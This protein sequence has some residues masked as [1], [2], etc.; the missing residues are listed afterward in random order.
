[1]MMMIYLGYM[2]DPAPPSQSVCSVHFTC[3]TYC[4]EQVHFTEL[5]FVG[6]VIWYVLHPWSSGRACVIFCVTA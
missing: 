3:T 1:M 6:V 4:E 2:L 5:V